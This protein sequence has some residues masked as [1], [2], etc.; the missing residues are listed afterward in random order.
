[1]CEW[2]LLLSIKAFRQL[3]NIVVAPTKDR[4]SPRIHLRI[5]I[6]LQLAAGATS[7]A[8]NVTDKGTD[9]W[10]GGC[11]SW[12]INDPP[13][14]WKDIP[15]CRQCEESSFAPAV[16][17][18]GWCD[19]IDA[20]VWVRVPSCTQCVEHALSEE[21][22]WGVGCAE[23]CTWIP[24]QRWKATMGCDSCDQR[25]VLK[26]GSGC[27]DE[28]WCGVMGGITS[29]GGQIARCHGCSG[30]TATDK[31]DTHS[32]ARMEE[33]AE[34]AS[35]G[36]IVLFTNNG[37]LSSSMVLIALVGTALLFTVA[38]VI[39]WRRQGASSSSASYSSLWWLENDH[40]GA[41]AEI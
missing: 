26:L 19:F 27:Y 7:V 3:G 17:C 38:G 18:S 5:M 21:S 29:G 16:A 22:E 37:V 13:S 9:N 28:R 36:E 25:T 30:S 34:S 20:L 35:H 12:C 24:N 15:P 2:V 10:L 33:T 6:L 11:E 39:L 1:M 31:S 4:R 32:T 41:Y 23:W 8:A 14:V 40:A